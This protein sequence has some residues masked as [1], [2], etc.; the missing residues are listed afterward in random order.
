MQGSLKSE[1]V[2]PKG[3]SFRKKRTATE[4]N[5]SRA[6]DSSAP[7]KA[8][9]LAQQA[10]GPQHGADQGQ[11]GSRAEPI[12]VDDDS[13]VTED[14]F[15]APGGTV[16]D[17]RVTPESEQALTVPSGDIG[18]A[19]PVSDFGKLIESD[20]VT[21]AMVQMLEMIRYLLQV[22]EYDKLL[23]SIKAAKQAAQEVSVLNSM[24]IITATDGRSRRVVLLI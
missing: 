19:D 7:S 21:K 4:L 1:Y 8:P 15:E 22:N 16:K 18:I 12:A 10:N 23:K 11:S 3:N 17:E 6:D 14:E 13:D 5:D 24:A 20:D 2:P 9:K